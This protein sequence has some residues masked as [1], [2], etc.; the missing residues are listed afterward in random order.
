[1]LAALGLHNMTQL[2]LRA[3]LEQLGCADEFID[4]FATAIMRVNYGQVYVL[5]H[6]H[7]HT[8]IHTQTH[9]HT[10]THTHTH[11]QSQ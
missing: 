5:T 10:H 3:R 8:H 7:T 1:M 6:T 11:T 9:K 4:E 2:T